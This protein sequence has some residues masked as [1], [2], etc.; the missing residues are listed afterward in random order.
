MNRLDFYHLFLLDLINSSLRTSSVENLYSESFLFEMEGQ[1]SD[2][3]L[4]TRENV[5]CLLLRG[6]LDRAKRIVVH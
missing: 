3:Y 6:E 2:V 5:C 1:V 4:D